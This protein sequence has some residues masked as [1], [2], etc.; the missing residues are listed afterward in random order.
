MTHSCERVINNQLKQ[1]S[2]VK[3]NQ[4]ATST[5]KLDHL[6][7]KWMQTHAIMVGVY[8]RHIDVRCKLQTYSIQQNTMQLQL[9]TTYACQ[10]ATINKQNVCYTKLNPKA[11]TISHIICHKFLSH[12]LPRKFLSHMRHINYGL[13]QLKLLSDNMYCS[14]KSHW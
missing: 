3:P 1:Q 13:Q 5:S 8:C 14:S 9:I 6:Q 7:A 10:S 12:K 11:V 2:Q 4:L